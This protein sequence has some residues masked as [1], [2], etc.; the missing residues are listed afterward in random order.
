[1]ANQTNKLTFDSIRQL[2]SMRSSVI[3]FIGVGGVSMYTLARLALYRGCTVTGSDRISNERT[4]DLIGRGAKILRGHDSS[5]VNGATLVVYSSAIS[6]SNPE[7]RGANAKNIPTVT[8]AQFMGAVMLDYKNRIG[9][10]GTHGKST[11]TAILDCIFSSAMTRPTTLS[12]AELTLGEP[13]RI[14]GNDTMIY[15]A[16]EYR[17]S[18][19]S[20][21]PT[22]ALALNLELDHTD[23]FS[24]I[25]ALKSSFIKALS[26]AK[27]IAI[28]NLDDEYLSEIIPDIKCKVVTFGQHERANWRYLITSFLDRGAEFT[29]YHHGVKIKK[30]R[31]NIPGCHNVQNAAAAAVAALEFGI[32]P[33][34][35]AAA[36]E[37][38]RGVPRRLEYVGEHLG[39]PVYYDYAHHPTEISAG[40]NTVKLMTGDFV[41]VVFKPHTYTRTASLWTELSGALSLADHII[42]T[43]IFPARE[44]PIKGI[45]SERLAED[46]GE[47][48]V[49][50]HDYD[51]VSC[52][53]NYTQGVIIV[54]GAG[55]LENVKKQLISK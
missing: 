10:S 46:I 22:I 11:T 17:D 41:T 12:G 32:A 31:L 2:L 14:G 5:Y 8:R 4:K 18:F 44:E 51:V 26:K 43:D 54:M 42:L 30:I 34:V 49:F 29:L 1:M 39:R 15:E 52:V 50:S 55:E 28:V 48:A 16:C 47:R 38:F 19:L 9:V 33:D 20:F 35:V 45:T 25:S 6:P 23:Y 27:D 37:S 21:S 53:D 13:L 7:M 40:I 24:G 36:I 3:H